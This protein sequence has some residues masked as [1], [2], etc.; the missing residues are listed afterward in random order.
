MYPLDP[1]PSVSLPVK[2]L[3]KVF[4]EVLLALSTTFFVAVTVVAELGAILAT[5]NAAMFVLT[6]VASLADGALLYFTPSMMIVPAGSSTRAM[7][8]NG[9]YATAIAFPAELACIGVVEV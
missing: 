2:S 7:S 6:F 3:T 8:T 5:S 1:Y 9:W 4:T